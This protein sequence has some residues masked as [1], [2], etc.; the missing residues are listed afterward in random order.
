VSPLVHT[1]YLIDAQ[2]I[3]RLLHLS[4]ANSVSTYQRRYPDM[5]RPVL[6][7]GAGRPRLWLRP[8]ILKWAR[9]RLR[10]PGLRAAGGRS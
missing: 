7:L 9:E 2:G 3:A 10:P 5:P 4:H 6:D 1:R 8:D